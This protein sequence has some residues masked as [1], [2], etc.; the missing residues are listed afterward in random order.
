MPLG[1]CSSYQLL[2]VLAYSES[3]H[4]KWHFTEIRAI[5]SRRYLLQNVALEIFL[6]SRTAVM[7]AFGDLGTVRRVVRALPRVGVGI[8][9]GLPQT[10]RASLMVGRQLFRASNMTHKWQRREISNFE[11]LMFLNT[12]AGRTYNDLNQ[13]PIFPWILTNYESMELD[14]SLPSNYRDLSK[15]IGALNQGRKEFFEDRFN[16]W[17][18]EGIP[19]F[20]YGT[21]YS[22]AAFVLNWLV[23]LEPFTTMF[24]SLQGGKFDHANRMFSSM[25]CAWRNCQRDTSDVKELTPELFYLPEMLVNMNGYNLGRDETGKALGDVHL[26]PWAQTPEEFIRINRMALESEIVSC[27]LHQ[28]IDL[29]FGYKQRGPEAVRATN[30]FYYLTYEGLVDFDS[31][32]DPLMREAVEN[33]I[34]SFGQTPSQLL[35][36]PHPPR[37]SAMTL[38]PLMW[39]SPPDDVCMVVKFPS[40][41]A[42]I[43]VSGNTYPALP[44]PAILTVTSAG[45][46]AVNRWHNLPYPPG[47]ARGS[48]GGGGGGGG[49]EVGSS[50]SSS[51]SSP[52]S[53]PLSLDPVLSLIA[54]NTVPSVRRSLGNNFSQKVRLRHSLFISTVDSRFIIA[55]GFWDNSFRV[56]NTDNARI[57]QI[58][59]GHYGVVRCLARSECNVVS[60]CLVASGS[61]DA[62][63][64]LWHWNARAQLITGDGNG[65][66]APS[67]K[68]ILTGHDSPVVALVLSA[69]LGLVV[70]GS[71][72]GAVLVHTTHGDL[73]RSLRPPGDFLS[74]DL[75]TL[76][77][78][79]LVVVKY[80]AGNLATFTINGKLLR[81]Q[82]HHDH[83]HSVLVSR[84]GEYLMT[85]G[86]RGV[87]EVWRTFTLA[88]LYAFPQCDSHIRTLALSHDQRYLVA[89]L[90]SGSLVVFNIDFNR[91]HYEYQQHI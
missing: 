84:D 53:L 18:H 65:L 91:W 4:G 14:L 40:N 52:T 66:D 44:H 35:M 11:Y 26:P 85:G 29:I 71:Q 28:W 34:R 83:L 6:A 41:S 87:V 42:V 50:A 58:I 24:L 32:T 19:P 17:D 10:R 1:V 59:F 37:A 89:G 64:R 63:V 5:F 43:H 31:I 23:R 75:M 39:T 60:D 54:G 48:E 15:P 21:H 86:E 46:F 90:S 12:I 69:E 78:E 73:L 13:Y 47:S 30:V 82:S 55:G 61:Q 3:I 74:P 72:G 27:Q 2:L 38:S 36:E 57:V 67:P 88:P 76:S 77:R 9:Y 8:K 7:F 20:H 62:T 81:H 49:G 33:Q 56:F 79:G 22:T 80:D 25:E 70:S 68:A 45:H 51:L 16:T